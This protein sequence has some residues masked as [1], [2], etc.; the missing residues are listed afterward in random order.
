MNDLRKSTADFLAKTEWANA[1]C[2]PLAGDMS[3]RRYF[4]LSQGLKTAILM[5]ASESMQPFRMMTDW[6][7]SANVS[8]PTI[9]NA[10]PEQG[11]LVLEDFGDTSVK[12]LLKSE[13]QRADEIFDLCISLLVKIRGSNAPDLV[14]PTA[15]ELVDWTRLA[16]QHYAG[17]DENGLFA[18]RLLL[19]DVLQDC[20][21][22]P[23]TVSLRDFHT[24]NLMWL[25]KRTGDL[26]LGVLDYQ[27]A[28]LTHAAYDLVSLLTDARTWITPDMRKSV[29]HRY[30]E[31]TGDEPEA[32]EMAFAA[33]SAQR[34]LRILG[35]F[36]RAKQHLEHLP[37]THKYLVEALDHPIF[38]PVREEVF[39]AIPAPE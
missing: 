24:E 17:I 25:P 3:S 26:R 4:R 30:L 33:F 36:A 32:F 1:A 14:C 35:V 10:R 15:A 20:L 39:S 29:V 12:Q 13:P 5:E 7:L 23:V 6:L 22:Q 38:A 27:D 37:N 28:F 21:A 19:T 18:F 8:A 11:L 34:N 31:I 16:D 9:L 2:V